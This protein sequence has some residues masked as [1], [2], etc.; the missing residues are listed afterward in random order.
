MPSVGSAQASSISI[1]LPHLQPE[2]GGAGAIKIVVDLQFQLQ[3]NLYI[4][5]RSSR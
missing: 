4:A 3:Y 2:G 1:G 5:T